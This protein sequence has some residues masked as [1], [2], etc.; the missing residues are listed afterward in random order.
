M[1][2]GLSHI[3]G[4][5]RDG[6]FWHWMFDIR[7]LNQNFECDP[8]T[9]CP[10]IQIFFAFQRMLT[11]GAKERKRLD[12]HQTIVRLSKE[13]KRFEIIA[14]RDAVAAL[15]QLQR[16]GGKQNVKVR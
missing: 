6:F 15:R 4:G 11:S 8:H 9:G 2:R 12:D 1:A 3:V 13:G 14:K 7:D 10:N 5:I 16:D